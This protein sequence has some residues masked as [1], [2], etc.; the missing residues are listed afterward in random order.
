MEE[1]SVAAGVEGCNCGEH[2]SVHGVAELLKPGDPR[3]PF[4][5]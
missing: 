2:R 1:L 5:R 3:G 4:F